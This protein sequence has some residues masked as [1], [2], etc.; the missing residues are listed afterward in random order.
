MAMG[1]SAAFE[2]VLAGADGTVTAFLERLVGEPIDADERRHHMAPASASN[3]LRVPQGH[4]LLH[5]S[6]VLRG[7]TSGRAYVDAATVL[8]V[9]RLPP[10]VIDRLE[11]GSDPIGRVLAEEGIAFVR[12]PVAL[13]DRQSRRARSEVDGAADCL[14]AR[15]YRVDVGD[16][17]VM[18]V[19]ER[20]LVTLKDFLTDR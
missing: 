12:G 2:A 3:D 19:T 10:S 4:P 8:V 16:V 5:R 7:R 17:P 6:A 20:F 1:D 18:I 9:D 15:S 14:L 13:V 11:T